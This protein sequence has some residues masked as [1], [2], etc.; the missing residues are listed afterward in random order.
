MQQFKLSPLFRDGAVLCRNKE[1]RVWGT[2]EEGTRLTLILR[3][4]WNQEL[5]R[6]E[7]TAKEGKLF[8]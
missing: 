6:D 7:G 3:N 5:G 4:E 2:A 8:S 1:I